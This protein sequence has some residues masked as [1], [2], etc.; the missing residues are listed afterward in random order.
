[1]NKRIILV[2]TISTMILAGA[3]MSAI[4]AQQNGEPEVGSF[5]ELTL[6][7]SAKKNRFVRLEPVPVTFTLS[8]QTEKEI[9]GHAA[10]SLNS[11]YLDLYMQYN[12]DEMQKIEYPSKEHRYFGVTSRR[13]KP[14]ERFRHQHL[15][16]LGLDKLFPE[17]GVYRLQVE[18]QDDN[19]KEKIKSN[20]I[21]ISIV[22]PTGVDLEA[23]NYLSTQVD[24][25]D[26]FEGVTRPSPEKV[27]EFVARFGD[28]SYAPYAIYQLGQFHFI[29]GD[30]PE[31]TRLLG[32]LA[33]RPDFVF[34]DRVLDYLNKSKDKLKSNR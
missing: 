28:S 21:E 32:K 20:I 30:Y 22:E 5:S 34:S 17:A 9:R 25:S 1:M 31:A 33:G 3:F 12:G 29:K 24:A 16:S 13:I 19:L 27:S 18:F 7:I 8:N 2:V 6:E 4:K 23:Y 15:I 26:F 14:R 11:K 10:L